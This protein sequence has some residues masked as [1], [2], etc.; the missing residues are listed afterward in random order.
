MLVNH[1]GS[2]LPRLLALAILVAPQ[3]GDA[4]DFESPPVLD[5]KVIIGDVPLVGEYYSIIEAVPTDG[6]MATVTIASPFGEF[7]ASGPGMVQSR[8]NEIRALAA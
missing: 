7:T 4:S 5:A 8:L 6:F 2:A 1:L 3:T